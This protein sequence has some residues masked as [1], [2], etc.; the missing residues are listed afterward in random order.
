MT[1]LAWIIR[2]TPLWEVQWIRWS[3][4]VKK[5]RCSLGMLLTAKER[6][7][8]KSTEVGLRRPPVSMQKGRKMSF[9][10]A[11][12]LDHLAFLDAAPASLAAPGVCALLTQMETRVGSLVRV[13]TTMARPSDESE[14]KTTSG[15]RLELTM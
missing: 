14:W 2:A 13:S 11:V 9:W 1:G 4:Q 8:R 15:R 10:A 5:A 3:D 6:V 12:V 7:R